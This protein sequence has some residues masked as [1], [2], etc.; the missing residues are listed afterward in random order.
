MNLTNTHGQDMFKHEDKVKLLW[1]SFKE[2]LGISEFTQ[3]H[4]DVNELFHVVD[5]LEDLVTPFGDDEINIV[6]MGLPSRKSPG[7]DGFNTNF[8]KKCWT[9]ISQD[10]YYLC[11]DFYNKN[12]C[13]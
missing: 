11:S 12:M 7:P 5:G 2:R 3:M 8:M 4:F 13:L 6:V 10:F 1:E 9:T